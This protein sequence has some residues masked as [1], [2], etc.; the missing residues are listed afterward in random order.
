MI[1]MP[2]SVPNELGRS[3]QLLAESHNKGA[4]ALDS[5][6]TEARGGSWI[7]HIKK[8]QEPTFMRLVWVGKG[9]LSLCL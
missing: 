1:E 9:T 7:R 2:P 6:R 4:S 3:P 8:E 5:T